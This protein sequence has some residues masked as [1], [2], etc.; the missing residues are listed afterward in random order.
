MYL[1]E[2]S[3]CLPLWHGLG[4]LPDLLRGRDKILFEAP[5]LASLLKPAP[6]FCLL[7]YLVA[8]IKRALSEIEAGNTLAFATG[9]VSPLQGTLKP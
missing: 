3:T 2:S 8:Q 1:V 9:K 5:P 7:Q 4:L 6:F